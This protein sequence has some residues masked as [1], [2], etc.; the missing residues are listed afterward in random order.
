M[1]IKE[2]EITIQEIKELYHSPLFALSLSGKE[3]AHS[4]F[5]AWLIKQE[6]NHKNPFVE[7]FIQDFYSK[8]FKLVGVEREEGDRDL[9][10]YYSDALGKAKCC[11]IEN[12]LKSIP[13]AKQLIGY[14]NDYTSSGKNKPLFINGLLT[15]IEQTIDLSDI[16]DWAFLSYEEIAKR[17]ISINNL[18]KKNVYYNTINEYAKDLNRITKVI[19]DAVKEINNKKTYNWNIDSFNQL[20]AIKLDDVFL[21][22][23]AERLR[24]LIE[25][26]IKKP[27]NNLES[28]WGNPYV[29][30][31]FNNKKAT[32]TVIYQEN[33]SN[34]RDMKDPEKNEIGRIG[35][36][37]EG[38]QF[39]IYCGPSKPD[40]KYKDDPDKLY[41]EM[42]S[43][44]WFEPFDR[45]KRVIRKS[46]TSMQGGRG[47]GRKLGY[48]K[49][50]TPNYT[51]IYQYYNIAN[52]IS[53]AEL[54]ENIVRELK[55]AKKIIDNNKLHF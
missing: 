53:Y 23:V 10:L 32:I 36:Q 1:I 48:C 28:K 49:Y 40:S 3:L 33:I 16:K 30:T 13:T 29:Y 25:D 21:K 50:I 6:I 2:C 46:S 37:I 5:W 41:N 19:G 7:V 9:T 45:T 38:N 42:V 12:K 52:D 43:I 55:D 15:G 27:D 39:R 54:I 24:I 14:V 34:E 26:E 31:C 4:N 47:M 20:A 35:V 44:N 18:N 11:F 51:H 8:G 22:H 17:I